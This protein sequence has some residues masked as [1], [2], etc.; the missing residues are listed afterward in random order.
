[1]SKNRGIRVA[2][3]HVDY[4]AG[5]LGFEKAARVVRRELSAQG[6]A[7]NKLRKTMRRWNYRIRKNIFSLKGL[8][9]IILTL[10]GASALGALN[11]QIADAS[12]RL[13]SLGKRIHISTKDLTLLFRVFE[14][15]GT[16]QEETVDALG[17]F[18]KRL[19]EASLGVGE[20]RLALSK[21]GIELSDITRVGQP[22]TEK[23]A[24]IADG[25][26]GLDNQQD[27]LFAADKL[28]GGVGLRLIPTLQ[29]GGEAIL[30]AATE[31]EKFGT[32]TD[33]EVKRLGKLSQAFKNTGH[34]IRTT[35]SKY[36]A[37]QAEKLIKWIEAIGHAVAKMG[38][39]ISIGNEAKSNMDA[40]GDSAMSAS[41]AFERL[42][43]SISNAFENNFSQLF[44]DGILNIAKNADKASDS[45][46]NML[47]QIVE[48]AIRTAILEPI[49]KD[50]GSFLS[51]IVKP[52]APGR[53][54]GGM[55]SAGN[56]YTVG[57]SGPETFVPNVGGR[58]V[59]NGA[60]GSVVN[61]NFSVGD[62]V[63][64]E[65]LDSRLNEFLAILPEAVRGI[66]RTE[67]ANH[68][69]GFRQGR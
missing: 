28:F 14:K 66:V 3:I 8:K 48:I 1:M 6:I 9:T 42:Q 36:L 24:L 47:Q 22:V 20:A 18:Q 2:G 45:L 5:T 52:S 57:E 29:E 21:L 13:D 26:K 43:D 23:I 33:E 10:V 51:G 67:N 16:L 7:I 62:G 65:M 64:T 38:K 44:A 58:I 32:L 59:P 68:S 60:G 34:A 39:L 69:R 30:A 25:I 40:V 17:E 46:K 55:V 15:G 31:L 12:K 61:V 35:F 41:S 37:N 49:G 27:R 19:S 50:F 54:V 53:A 63:N 11:K 56:R 4:T